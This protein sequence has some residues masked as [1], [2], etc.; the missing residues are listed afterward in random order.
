MANSDKYRKDGAKP[1]IWEK[2]E[3]KIFNLEQVPAMV[4]A[5]CSNGTGDSAECADGGGAGESCSLGNQFGCC[6]GTGDIDV[7]DRGSGVAE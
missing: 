5:D 1:P 2:P 3:I 4:G 6:D 7:C